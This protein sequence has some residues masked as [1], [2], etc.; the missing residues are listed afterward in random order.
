MENLT[1]D[2]FLICGMGSLGQYCLFHL[3]RFAIANYDLKISGV[4]LALPDAWEMPQAKNLL[5]RELILGD[6]RQEEVLLQAGVRYCRAILLT[7]DDEGVNV[8]AAIAARRLNPDIRLIIRSARPRLN[9]LLEQQLGDVVALEPTEIAA[10]AFALEGL[11][12]GIRGV[13]DLGEHQLQ[14]VE[15]ELS[16][17]DR[18]FD[19]LPVHQ[20]HQPS[21]RFIAAQAHSTR[22]G[23]IAP[24]EGASDTFHRVSPES[25]LKV[26]DRVTYVELSPSEARSRLGRQ[27]TA[28]TRLLQQL[29][30]ACLRPRSQWRRL[31]QWLQEQPARQV[32]GLGLA[33]ALALGMTGILAFKW[34]VPTMTWRKAASTSLT[35]LLG[36][37]G[38]V[39]GG[40]DNDP[41]PTWLQGLSA[42]ISLSSIAFVLGGLSLF[43]ERAISSRFSF[44][45][46][47]PVIPRQSHAIV[48]GLGRVGQRTMRNLQRFR[49]SLVA[50]ST[51]VQS[52]QPD[53]SLPAL[54]APLLSGNPGELLERANFAQ[55]KSVIAVT[56]DQL[57]NLEIALTVREA[58]QEQALPLP[59]LV[60]RTFDQR[61]SDNLAQLLPDVRVLT[62]HAIAAQAFA[63]AAFGEDVLAL[64]RLQDHT[65]LATEYRVELGDSLVGKQLGQVAY[66]YGVM[67]IFHQRVEAGMVGQG[68]I[69]PKDDCLLEVGDRL[70]VLASINGLRR[71]Q[72]GEAFPPQRWQLTIQQPLNS[73]FLQSG[74]DALA[75]IAGLPLEEARVFMEQLPGTVALLMYP[76]Q[77]ARLKHKLSRQLAVELSLDEG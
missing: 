54:W 13:V 39:F 69:L 10:A 47:K 4:D 58:M 57:L 73:A 48:I 35:L 74:G 51:T 20:I 52:I 17:G 53:P 50:I 62:V 14:I 29:L 1:V 21:Y 36:G 70:V 5:D 23:S 24:V 6:C 8:Q 55:A 49:Q 7:T 37:Y 15:Q 33:L 38:D 40:L 34:G 59:R 25:V 72:Y 46:A 77:A 64:F 71:I 65:V 75:Q 61:F 68:G 30:A 66:G 9:Q 16:F 67:P 56:D 63:G 42:F 26:G 3:K 44:L 43:A 32:I 45:R 41:V 31:R 76:Y 28:L 22:Q 27:R 2:R 11:G 12:S 19:Q 18:R 60:V